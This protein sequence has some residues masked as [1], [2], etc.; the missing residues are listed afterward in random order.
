MDSFH[1]GGADA[2]GSSGAGGSVG[3][4]VDG[5]LLGAMAPDSGEISLFDPQIVNPRVMCVLGQTMR[6][7]RCIMTVQVGII[8]PFPMLLQVK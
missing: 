5:L 2:L 7:A 3:H 1:R 8:I 6:L 4:R